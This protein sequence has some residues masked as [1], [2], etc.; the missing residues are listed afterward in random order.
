M[1]K[2]GL[3][4]F[5]GPSIICEFGEY[6]SIFEYTE[7]AIRN[8]LFKDTINYKILPSP[9]WSYDYVTWNENNIRI[10]KKLKNDEHGYEVLQGNGKVKGHLLGGCLD[11]FMMCNGTR[12]WPSI[13][14]WKDAILFI[15]TSEDKPSPDFVKWTMR[16]LAAQGILK[17]IKGIIVGKPQN[18][19]FYEEYK[20][21]ILQVVA[22]EEDLG[23]IPIFY[24]VNFGHSMPI[25]ILPYGIITEL[26]CDVETIT[27][28]ENATI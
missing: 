8:I 1:Y 25:V 3:V 16:N 11:V 28:L 22:I 13:N 9:Q 27:L 24:N 20:E 26:N 5:Y 18:E 12:I 21:V 6:V 15:E 17:V 4:S 2:A 19:V 7:E 14:E 23:D 10:G